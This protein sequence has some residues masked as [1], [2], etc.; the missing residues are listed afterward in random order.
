VTAQADSDAATSTADLVGVDDVHIPHWARIDE[1][2]VSAK[3][4]RVA[5]AAPRM[6]WLITRRAWR[7]AP[8]LTVLAGIAQLAAGATT[9]FGLLATANVFTR[10]LEQGPTPDRLVAAL[11]ALGWVVVAYAARGLLD[12]AVGAA[13]AALAPKIERA[14]QDELYAAVIEVDLVAFDDPDFVELVSNSS[15]QGLM[16]LRDAGTVVGDLIASLVSVAAAVATAAVLHPALAPV[17]VLTAIPQAWASIRAAKLSYEYFLNMN[18]RRLRLNV[19]G[20]LITSRV[21]AAEVRAFT[22]QATLLAEHRRIAESL[23]R[24]AIK[25]E[26]R[27]TRI[28]LAVLIT[29]RPANVRHADQIIV[30]DHGR[31]TATGTHDQLITQP[32]TYRDLFTLQARAYES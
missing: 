17:V 25:V 15:V 4:A 10:L 13:E 20:G 31:I 6:A 21:D 2:V 14:F 27:K 18:T 3:L 11:P 30:L 8:T 23:T 16:R 29:H 22:T 28:R 24:E 19:T 12:A 32:G 5:R 1:S 7:V 26:H 9:A